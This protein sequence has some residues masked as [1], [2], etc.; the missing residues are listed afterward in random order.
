MCSNRLLNIMHADLVRRQCSDK[1]QVANI[2][3]HCQRSWGRR[4]HVKTYSKRHVF[5]LFVAMFTLLLQGC[6]GAGEAKFH[7]KLAGKK[8]NPNKT[9]FAYPVTKNADGEPLP[10]PYSIV[11]MSSFGF[12]PKKDFAGLSADRLGSM[13]DKFFKGDVLVLKV[14]FPPLP[15]SPNGLS[16]FSATHPDR[17][18][19]RQQARLLH[20]LQLGTT[21]QAAVAR[22][23]IPTVLRLSVD[24]Y[25]NTADPPRL[26]GRV[27]IQRVESLKPADSLSQTAATEI[28]DGRFVAPILAEDLAANNMKLLL[29]LPDA[30]PERAEGEEEKFGIR[31][32]FYPIPASS[33]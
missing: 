17:D 14:M 1:A 24:N 18:Q 11:V 6:G 28:I 29:D 20:R 23:A 32:L 4:S 10:Q 25:V 19:Q 15:A 21:D 33:Q 13:R 2:N 16:F 30:P 27:R 26:E 22:V 8:F 5:C 3:E 9:V 31:D 12:D 7:G